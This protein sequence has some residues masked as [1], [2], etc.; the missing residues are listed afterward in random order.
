MVKLLNKTDII[1]DATS[2]K[3][4]IQTLT[5]INKFLK[6]KYLINLTPSK[7]GEYIVPYINKKKFLKLST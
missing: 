1:F 6:K 4:N 2:A 3:S 5:R 7:A